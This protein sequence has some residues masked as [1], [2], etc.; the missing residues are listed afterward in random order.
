MAI[1]EGLVEKDGLTGCHAEGGQGGD[2][3]LND[4]VED[5]FPSW[6]GKDFL[7]HGRTILDFERIEFTLG[8]GEG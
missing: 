7:Y 8:I 5:L 1:G 2:S 6:L 3:G 4:G